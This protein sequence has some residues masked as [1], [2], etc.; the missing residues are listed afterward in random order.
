MKSGFPVRGTIDLSAG[1][2]NQSIDLPLISVPE[3]YGDGFRLVFVEGLDPP[4]YLLWPEAEEAMNL[5]TG[6]L[7][8]SG[9]RVQGGR[10]DLKLS[11]YVCNGQEHL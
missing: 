3:A 1:T 6:D 11:G 2:G 4:S 10:L 9:P 8:L 7:P 5:E